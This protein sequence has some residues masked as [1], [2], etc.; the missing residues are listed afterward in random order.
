MSQPNKDLLDLV[1]KLR[2]EGIGNRDK[3][4][5]I[6]DKILSGN[7][8]PNEIDDY[9]KEL[10]SK[11]S[12]V[13]KHAK[14]PKDVI[15]GLAVFFIVIISFNVIF[16][17][18]FIPAV[19]QT[20]DGTEIDSVAYNIRPFNW[21]FSVSPFTHFVILVIVGGTLGGAIHGLAKLAEN[22]RKHD[23]ESV[24][25]LW[26]LTRPFLGIALALTV[27]V[28]IKGGLITTTSIEALNPYGI[29]AISILVG[30]SS[31]KVTLKLKEILSSLFPTKD[32][33]NEMLDILKRRLANGEIKESDYEDLKK[34]LDD[35]S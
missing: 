11:F 8:L 17:V 31:E 7:P 28:A 23:I 32:P 2:K 21:Q 18:E 25:G 13:E 29:T 14:L 26:Y 15:A 27:Y 1:S 9:L 30:L 33:K 34:H 4:I 20:E 10:K 35:K 22:T 6:E 19:L 3:L 5:K 16:L 24:D 12:V